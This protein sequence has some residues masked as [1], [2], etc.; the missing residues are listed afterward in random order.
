LGAA[1]QAS[2]LI[3]QELDAPREVSAGGDEEAAVGFDF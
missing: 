2:D 3:E 1:A